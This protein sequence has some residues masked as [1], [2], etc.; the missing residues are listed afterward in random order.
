MGAMS[1]LSAWAYSRTV[2][3]E[4]IRVLPDVGIV[5]ISTS[6]VGFKLCR[7][8]AWERAGPMIINEVCF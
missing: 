4:T 8:L 5:L 1:V 6:T 2:A 7:F 3:H